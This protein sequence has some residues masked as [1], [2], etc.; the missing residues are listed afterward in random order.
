MMAGRFGSGYTRFVQLVTLR[1]ELGCAANPRNDLGSKMNITSDSESPEDDSITIQVNELERYVEL[2]ANSL[3]E[4][5]FHIAEHSSLNGWI[6]RGQSDANWKLQPKLARLPSLD[7]HIAVWNELDA[8]YQACLAYQR[9]KTELPKEY[10]AYVAHLRRSLEYSA[11]PIYSL[12]KSLLEDWQSHAVQYMNSEPKNEI[13]WLAIGQHHG[14]ATR[15]LDWTRNPL[16]ASFFA[17]ER[18]GDCD[19]AVYALQTNFQS[20]PKAGLLDKIDRSQEESLLIVKIIP[21]SIIQ[22]IVRQR[23][24]FTMNKWFWIDLRQ[25]VKS[26]TC[27]GH[28]ATIRIPSAAARRILRE[29]VSLGIDRSMLFPDL[30]GLA[31]HLNFIKSSYIINIDKFGDQ[32]ECSMLRH[33]LS[34]ANEKRNNLPET[35]RDSLGQFVTGSDTV[36]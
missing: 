3:G 2:E 22:R 19:S 8:H 26:K 20:A 10:D 36:D 27:S 35:I 1:L 9:D 24:L 16:I 5:L 34:E 17:L 12:E 28:L 11:R 18:A 15:L 13:E 21:T 23:G 7:R 25:L 32:Q 14:L 31:E 30:D 4:L 33:L 6:F 29:L